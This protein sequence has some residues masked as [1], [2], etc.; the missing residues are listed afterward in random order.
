MPASN[1]KRSRSSDTK[2]SSS[3][4]LLQALSNVVFQLDSFQHED[5]SSS[6]TELADLFE[7]VSAIEDLRSKIR[8]VDE[9]LT[10]TLA[11][12]KEIEEGNNADE[13]T[14]HPPHELKSEEESPSSHLVC[15]NNIDTIP[16]E[17]IRQVSQSGYLDS[18]DLGRLLLR[19]T[20]SFQE[21]LTCEFVYKCLLEAHWR[22]LAKENTQFF[23]Q[24]IEAEGGYKRTF[25]ALEKLPKV[26]GNETPSLPDTIKQSQ[27]SS[28]NIRLVVSLWKKSTQLFT[29]VLSENETEELMTTGTIRLL[30]ST[31][32]CCTIVN[33]YMNEYIEK[34]QQEFGSR[35]NWQMPKTWPVAKMHCIRLDKNQ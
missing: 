25:Q 5:E 10:K 29:R 2:D 20:K 34:F 3:Q 11:H 27:L 21:G 12:K 8:H 6:S 9:V 26:K 7:S 15:H 23:Q 22:L 14:K 35:K 13:T 24:I 30:T 4:L 17:I 18:V 32:Y 28:K 33:E 1:H 16:M 19:S 31:N